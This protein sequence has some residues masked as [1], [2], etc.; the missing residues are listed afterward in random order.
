MARTLLGGLKEVKP[1]WHSTCVQ[2]ALE[3]CQY[4]EKNRNPYNNHQT[5]LS[6]PITHSL[7][8]ENKYNLMVIANLKSGDAH[9]TTDC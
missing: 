4:S 3:G 6:V 9:I 2:I 8:T 5:S 1:T 7:L